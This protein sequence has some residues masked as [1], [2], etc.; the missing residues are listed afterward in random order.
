[1]NLY[2]RLLLMSLIARFRPACDPLGPCLTPFRVMPSDLDLLRHMNNGKYLSILDLARADLVIRSGSFARM[3]KHGFFPVVA[4]EMIQFKKSLRLFDAFQVETRVLG[5][6]TKA[7]VLQHRFLRA[8]EAVAMA[9]VWTCFVKR[10]GVTVDSCDVLA[11]A[12][13][14]GPDCAPPSWAKQWS[15]LRKVAW[16]PSAERAPALQDLAES[17]LETLE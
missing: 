15:D 1:M 9:I 16:G 10:S 13:Y 3:Q 6:D 8:G 11:A 5:W 14:K 4:T 7:F 17:S 2:F 12:G